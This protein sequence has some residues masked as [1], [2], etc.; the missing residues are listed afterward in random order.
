MYW[1]SERQ[2][3]DWCRAASGWLRP[4]PGVLDRVWEASAL[5]RTWLAPAPVP[6]SGAALALT[7]VKSAAEL[8]SSESAGAL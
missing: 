2:L 7:I 6:V 8:A 3:L 1:W 5:T 4:S